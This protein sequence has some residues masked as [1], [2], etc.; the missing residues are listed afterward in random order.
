MA[1]ANRQ[2]IFALAL[3]LLSLPAYGDALDT[4]LNLTPELLSVEMA[5][6]RGEARFGS[7]LGLKLRNDLLQLDLDYRLQSQLDET[8]A[9]PALSQR[10]GASLRS[11]LLNQVLGMDAAIRAGST[12]RAGGDSYVY[13][14]SPGFAK[15]LAELGRVNVRYEYLLDKAAADAVEQETTG[16]SMGLRGSTDDGRLDWW[17]SYHSSDVFGGVEQLESSERLEFAS[18]LQLIPELR[19]EVSGHSL[20]ETRFDSGLVNELYT[21]TLLGAGLSWS[22]SSQYS[23]ALKVNSLEES[24][25]RTQDVYGSG[26]VSWFP[27]PDLRF[28]LSYGD[29]LHEGARGV[30]LETRIDLGG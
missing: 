10:V 7:G 20:D 30:L 17:G 4:T 29:H 13:S 15:S 26:T 1:G 3:P 14:V 5:P 22:P 19:L 2:A 6:A 12:I 9:D 8:E 21:E 11:S 25:G 28:I 18:G 27:Q 16:I 24:R 23:V